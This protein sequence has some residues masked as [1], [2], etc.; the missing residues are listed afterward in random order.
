KRND[1]AEINK[2]FMFND[3]K[4]LFRQSMRLTDNFN[5]P[6]VKYYYEHQKNLEFSIK[7]LILNVNFSNWSDLE[8]KC[9]SFL[10]NCKTY[11]FSGSILSQAQIKIGDNNGCELASTMIESHVGEVEFEE[12][13]YINQYIALYKLIKLNLEFIENYI[14]EIEEIKNNCA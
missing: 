10:N 11:D 9:I 12:S 2:D 6:V 3:M 8:M 13:N 1:K 7:E 5:E 4:D 14:S